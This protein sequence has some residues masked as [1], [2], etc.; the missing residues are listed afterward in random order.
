M[1]RFRANPLTRR[2]L[3]RLRDEKAV[4]V[5]AWLRKVVQQAL[6][7]EFP[8]FADYE[9][10]QTPEPEPQKTPAEP[11]S[12][13][14]P[15]ETE[16]APE[17]ESQKTPI[18]WKPRRIDEDTWGAV[19]GPPGVAELPDNDDLPGTQ[20]IVTDRRGESWS[21]TITEVVERTDTNIVVKTSGRP[22][23]TLE[24]PPDAPRGLG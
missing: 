20:I 19:T 10:N 3:D 1:V 18:E 17:P 5:S 11:E 22:R 7:R 9:A 2:L 23:K 15:G 14:T 8:D 24:G 6:E 16:A 13:K 12:Q 21:T 4:N